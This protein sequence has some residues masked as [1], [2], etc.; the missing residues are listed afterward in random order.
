M[1]GIVKSLGLAIAL[2]LGSGQQA[3]AGLPVIDPTHIA[4]AIVNTAETIMKWADYIKNFKEYYATVNAVYQGLKNWQDMGWL[5]ALKL[6]ELPWF[7]GIP[8]IEDMRNVAGAVAMTAE[9]LNSVFA[10]VKWYQRMLND[11][12]FAANEGAKKRLQIMQRLSYRQMRRRM[13]ITKAMKKLQEENEKLGK[14][15]KDIQAQIEAESKKDPAP[16][17]T[18]Q[19]LAARIAGIQAKMAKNKDGL[20][21]QVEAMQQQ[22]KA[23]KTQTLDQLH[24]MHLDEQQRAAPMR[25]FWKGL[26]VK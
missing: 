2:M 10:D 7:D 24:N 5:D 25:D 15:L 16:T 13:T 26:L 3:H 20:Y 22:E 9:E 11:P 4:T 19:A 14:Q 8:G 1:R 6:V 12:R 17:A 23:E 21:A 18:I